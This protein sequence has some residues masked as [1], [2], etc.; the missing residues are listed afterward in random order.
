[1][2]RTLQPP[3]WRKP[4]GYA[5][6]VVTT[7][8]DGARMIFVAGMIGWDENCEFQ[9]DD[10]VAQFQQAL[11]NALAV[12]ACADA[13]P[14]H[15]VR[16]NLYATDIHAYRTR[17]AEV[18]KA[19]RALMGKNFPAMTFVAVSALVEERALLEIELTAV[20]PAGGDA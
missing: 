18:G 19:Y 5:N 9:S 7:V 2:R 13:R 16:F 4:K 11:K 17:L 10:F 8:A 1:M 6:G 15:V 3:G 12:L 14:E 20:A